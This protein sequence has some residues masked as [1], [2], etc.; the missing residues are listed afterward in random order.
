MNL[1]V[2]F[3]KADDEFHSTI[4]C[5]W[6][7]IIDIH[8]WNKEASRFF[9]QLFHFNQAREKENSFE[10]HFIQSSMHRTTTI[11]THVYKELS[12]IERAGGRDEDEEEKNWYHY[13]HHIII[14][15]HSTRVCRSHHLTYIVSCNHFEWCRQNRLLK[16]MSSVELT[17]CYITLSFFSSSNIDSR[18]TR[19]LLTE[20]N[21][22]SH[23]YPGKNQTI[24]TGVGVV[25]ENRLLDDTL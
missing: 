15:R 11:H 14:S 12:T 5:V 16:S 25:V 23:R 4:I 22:K 18:F 21:I 13:Q 10:H 7:W 2:V 6:K 3:L 8:A 24:G 20:Q 19:F 17:R 1:R 9:S